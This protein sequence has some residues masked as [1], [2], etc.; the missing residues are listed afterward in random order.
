MDGDVDEFLMYLATERGLSE[1]YQLLVGR[2]LEAFEGWLRRRGG[3]LEWRDVGAEAVSG[4]LM[5]RKKQGL[6]ASSVR[7]DAVAVRIFFRF[8]AARRGWE[9]NPADH[10][11]LPRPERHLPGT[12]G[13]EEVGRLLAAVDTRAPLG[14]RDLAMLELLYS[15]GL[16]VSELCDVRL[17]QLDLEAGF[18]RVTGK[19]SKTRIVPVG[20]PALSALGEYLTKERPGLVGPLSGA[21]IFLSVRGRKLTTPRIRQLL[22]RYASHAGL[23][24]HVYPH[25]LR[26]SFATHLLAGGADLRVIQEMLGHADISTTQVYTHVESDRLRSVIKRFHPRA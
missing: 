25:L 14:L 17:E 23:E 5:D 2:S 7:L 12:L 6:Q 22:N 18:I 26:H 4:F 9:E 20:K 11:D 1:N 10:L 16:R 21:E 8:L 19:G 15:S 13:G 24:K 3:A